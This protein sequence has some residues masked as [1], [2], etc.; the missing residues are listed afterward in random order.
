[1]LN[2]KTINPSHRI[3][4]VYKL[5][6]GQKQS[7]IERGCIFSPTGMTYMRTDR[8][9]K[10]LTTGRFPN[11]PVRFFRYSDLNGMDVLDVGTGGG[12]LVVDM[13]KLGAKVIGIDISPS[14]NF[15]KHRKW[16]KKANA[17][18]TGF[19]K[20]SFDRIFSSWS[21]FMAP[22]NVAFKED[23]L[24]ELKRILRPGGKIRLCGII[25]SDIKKIVQKIRGFKITYLPKD[26][27]VYSSIELTK[28][29]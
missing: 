29:K 7:A 10:W 23:V 15:I 24:I 21:I 5:N 1:M 4:F 19:A 8:D 22:E 17:L 2:T 27:D 28:I 25:A 6:P 13:M 12:Q 18:H 9:I 26:I 16:F 20:N 14:P 3:S 11:A